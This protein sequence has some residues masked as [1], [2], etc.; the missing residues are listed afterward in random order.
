M[1]NTALNPRGKKEEAFENGEPTTQ[2]RDKKILKLYKKETN[3]MDISEKPVLK[4]NLKLSAIQN[5]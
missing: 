3:G 4:I 1:K 2:W 5:S